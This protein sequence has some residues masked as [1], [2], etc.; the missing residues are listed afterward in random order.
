MKLSQSA[1]KL[2]NPLPPQ[3]SKFQAK[4]EDTCNINFIR[5]IGI[6]VKEERKPWEGGAKVEALCRRNHGTC[7]TAEEIMSTVEHFHKSANQFRLDMIVLEELTTLFRGEKIH[8]FFTEQRDIEKCRNDQYAVEGG[9]E[10]FEKFLFVLQDKMFY[11]QSQLR[12]Y[13]NHTILDHANLVCTVCNP[14]EG[15]FFSKEKIDVNISNCW[16]F[17]DFFEFQMDALKVYRDLLLPITNLVYCDPE[18]EVIKTDVLDASYLENEK[19]LYECHKDFGTHNANC[20]NI[21]QQKS[22]VSYKFP[23]NFV[24][25]TK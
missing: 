18:L 16:E 19:I 25:I 13:R 10:G 14:D 12:R 22:L 23:S 9:K 5:A 21:C 15:K 20:I 24:K 6:E 8:E 3:Y 1:N 17:L 4:V 2:K 7:C 11:I